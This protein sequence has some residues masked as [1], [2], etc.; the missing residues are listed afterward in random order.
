MKLNKTFA[1]EKEM[2]DYV[3]QNEEKIFEQAKSIVKHAD[4]FGGYSEPMR[5]DFSTKSIDTE[6]ILEQGYLTAKLAINTTNI[7]D[8]H[9]DVHIPGLWDKSLKENK[10]ILHLQE[11]DRTFRGIIAE[12]DDLKAYAETRTWK[13][14]GFNLEGKTE[15]LTFDSVVREKENAFMFEK[16]AKGKV[17]EHSVGMQYV[18]MVTCVDDEDYP[19]FKEN[20]DKYAPMVHNKEM[21]EGRKV[22][23]AILEAKTIEGSAVPLG[24]NSFTPT[25]EIKADPQESQKDIF[26]QAVKEWRAERKQ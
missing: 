26:R 8:S 23:W 12:G 14:L 15:V 19:S 5:D 10:R 17:R 9:D 16:Y 13:S 4:G 1:S 22:F 11:H 7:L 6:K 3:T 21:L 20:W 25:Q 24:S 2:L 18:K